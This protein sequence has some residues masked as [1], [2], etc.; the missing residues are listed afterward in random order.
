MPGVDRRCPNQLNSSQHPL[1]QSQ[2]PLSC[3]RQ[4][5]GKQIGAA[6]VTPASGSPLQSG[7]LL[8]SPG[9]YK[10][11]CECAKRCPPRSRA[12]ATQEPDEN[13]VER[14]SRGKTRQ[15]NRTSDRSTA[16]SS[17]VIGQSAR[18]VTADGQHRPITPSRQRTKQKKK[19]RRGVSFPA[20]FQRPYHSPVEPQVLQPNALVLR[21]LCDQFA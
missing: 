8:L 19:R 2:I 3:L 11:R 16:G 5:L 13:P 21:I 6:C 7:R 18:C 10:E 17:Y 9:A 20:P 1:S 15:G 14:S 12:V 4:I